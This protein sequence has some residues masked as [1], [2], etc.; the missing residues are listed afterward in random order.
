MENATEFDLSEAA[1]QW[2][3]GLESSPAFRPENLDELEAHLRDSATALQSGGLTPP[4]AFLIA[5][6]RLGGRAELG[7]EFGKANVR[8]LWLHRSLWMMLGLLFYSF[9]YRLSV[10]PQT[11]ILDLGL[12]WG[13]STPLV[14]ILD[15]LVTFALPLAG[16]AAVSWFWSRR[17]QFV[18]R[19]SHSGLR[20]WWLTGLALGF[21]HYASYPFANRLQAG[22]HSLILG[23]TFSYPLDVLILS[24]WVRW[25]G[26]EPLL[27]LVLVPLLA[28]YAQ[29]MRRAASSLTSL[30]DATGIAAAQRDLVQR[31]QSQG[32]SLEEACFLVARRQEARPTVAIEAP[33]TRQVLVERALW[34]VAGVVLNRFIYSFL[35]EPCW[36]IAALNNRL[37][38]QASA[39]GH[40]L[41]GLCLLFELGVAAAFMAAFWRFVT[42]G[43]WSIEWFASL[44]MKRPGQAALGLALIYIGIG[45]GFWLL[46]N[47]LSPKTPLGIEGIVS[48]WFDWQGVLFQM[49]M[50]VALL[51]WLAR[52][53][54]KPRRT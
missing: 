51:L 29:R 35:L 32:L 14:A 41:G 40:I 36:M 18:A 38:N 13:I 33:N 7:R 28:S 2:R 34:M 5:A 53:R 54:M 44:C 27:L 3:K 37:T 23:P 47:V 9:I 42:R 52:S 50:P 48:K 39:Y 26:I 1:R 11:V 8:D 24:Q 15:S 17:K 16:I 19:L 10:V 31:L 12:S 43:H 22:L 21:L 20:W 4:E 49:V 6:R 45:R 30:A 25:T 46:A